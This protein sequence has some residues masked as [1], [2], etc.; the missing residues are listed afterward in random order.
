MT[1][2]S[3]KQEEPLYIKRE[4]EKLNTR[5]IPLMKKTIF[6]GAF[7]VPLITFSFIGLYFIFVMTSFSGDMAVGIVL[8]ALAGA[9][10]LALFRESL[11]KGKEMRKT[12]L[13]YMKERVANSDRLPEETKLQYVKQLQMNPQKSYETFVR[14]LQHEENIRKRE[15]SSED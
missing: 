2:T 10:G 7:S 15:L 1:P 5:L 3:S 14:F 12:S 4:F 9:L 6:L 11:H 13:V 8:F